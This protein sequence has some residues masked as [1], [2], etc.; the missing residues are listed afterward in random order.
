MLLSVVHKNNA[1]S[2]DGI[3]F[4]GSVAGLTGTT[5]ATGSNARFN[6]PSH[7]VA[8]G[9]GS[10]YISDSGNHKIRKVDQFGVVTSVFGTGSSGNTNT[11]LNSPRGLALDGSNNLYIADF[12]NNR[13]LFL[14]NGASTSTTLATLNKVEEIAVNPS[15]T[16][17]VFRTSVTSS[18]NLYQYRNG[19]LEGI[20]P[21]T[22]S[23]YCNIYPYNIASVACA[24][25]GLFYYSARDGQFNIQISMF[26]MTLT[27]PVVYDLSCTTGSFGEYIDAYEV[28]TGKIILGINP[29]SIGIVSGTTFTL[30]GFTGDNVKYN[31]YSSVVRNVYTGTPF[32]GF[33]FSFKGLLD[34][35]PIGDTSAIPGTISNDTTNSGS[36]FKVLGFRWDTEGWFPPAPPIPALDSPTEELRMNIYV[37]DAGTS[38][39]AVSTTSSLPVSLG[40]TTT[41]SNFT[42]D[43]AIYNGVT[44]SNARVYDWPVPANYDILEQ[45]TGLTNLAKYENIPAD[46]ANAF[47]IGA[48][49]V[50]PFIEIETRVVTVTP[51]GTTGS[52]TFTTSKPFNFLEVANLSVNIIPTN[53][54]T[55]TFSYFGLASGSVITP[56]C[57]I[58]SASA[59]KA[60]T[61][62]SVIPNFDEPGSGILT[63]SV[64]FAATD[65]EQNYQI[66]GTLKFFPW[67][68][69]STRLVTA[70]FTPVLFP[71]VSSGVTCRVS[72]IAVNNTQMTIDGALYGGALKYIQF[73]K[74][75]STTLYASSQNYGGIRRYDITSNTLVR[76]DSNSNVPNLNPFAVFPSS[77]EMIALVPTP[78][79]NNIQI[80]ENVY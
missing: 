27:P 25:D 73:P 69:E 62:L 28:S 4:A 56:G 26:N 24:P 42:G 6:A 57:G 20:I 58:L 70:V 41:L 30:S 34:D 75:D 52:G 76:S 71:T 1:L 64:A 40:G 66:V 68:G 14:S 48:R 80:Y 54:V 18:Q 77:V 55:N 67:I 47:L 39:P 36:N 9:T 2:Q 7:I 37:V 59:G 72:T 49:L 79:S 65:P 15:G 51:N 74:E 60:N 44:F 8:D 29:S 53:R 10:F 78:A 17:M 19:V 13:V 43:F 12:S 23:T 45:V 32:L 5:D 63:T 46:I 33:N 3:T 22:V 21:T 31:G 11:T 61:V 16:E 38:F 50:G 35:F